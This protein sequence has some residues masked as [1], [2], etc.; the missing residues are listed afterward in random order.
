MNGKLVLSSGIIFSIV[1]ILFIIPFA[2]ANEYESTPVDFS[3]VIS[4]P[5]GAGVD[6]CDY[7]NEC[8]LPFNVSVLTGKEITWSND[9]S[10]AHTVT[11]GTPSDG[12]DGNFDSG[13]IAPKN[14]FSVTLDESGEYPYYCMIHPWARG[15]LI[16]EDNHTPFF[17]KTDKNEYKKGDM[18]TISGIANLPYFFDRQITGVVVSPDSRVVTIMQLQPSN[19]YFETSFKIGGTMS[20]PGEYIATFS[21]GYDKNQIIINY[22]DEEPTITCDESYPDVCIVSYPPDLN[23]GDIMYANFRVIG[24]DPHRFDGDNDGIGCES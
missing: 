3:G 15:M 21:H 11:S 4:I 5:K 24:E 13:L 19:T 1:A 17:L 8:F 23:C 6:G 18:I 16:V 10:S 12:P 14:T 7:T 22:V 9:D 2:Y 20:E